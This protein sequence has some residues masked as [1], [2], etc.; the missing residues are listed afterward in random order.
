[1]METF[2]IY[3][4]KASG[5]L[6]LFYVIYQVF[7]K[8]DTF[9]NAN[10][11][12][13]LA[14]IAAAFLGPMVLITKYI[15]VTPVPYEMVEALPYAEATSVPATGIDWFN[16]AFYAYLIGLCFLFIRFIVQLTSLYNICKR[17][18]RIKEDG[19]VIIE[20]VSNIAPFSFLNTIVYN[21]KHYSESELR[22]IISHEKAHCSQRHTLDVLFAHFLTIILWINPFSWLYKKS[23]QQNLEF[24]ADAYAIN[25]ISSA[26]VYQYTLLKVSGNQFCTAITNNFHNSLIKKRIVM[27]QK[28]KSKKRSVFK[29]ALI[30][31]A[32]ALF[33]L[34]FNTTEV[35]VPADPDTE[36]FAFSLQNSKT[37]QIKVDK[38]T[39]DSDLKEIKREL[40]KK[41][42]DF[43]Y[44]IVRNE[45]DEI[46]TLNIHMAVLKKE[47]KQFSASSSYDNDGEP[48]DDIVI[49]YDPDSNTFSLG[50]EP[51]TSKILHRENGKSVWVFDD[52]QHGKT[53]EIEDED[54]KEVI[55]IDGEKVTRQEYEKMKKEGKLHD[56]HIKIER[57]D[58]R[59]NSDVMIIRDS[60]DAHD[61]D[62]MSAVSGSFLFIDNDGKEPLYILDG[63]EV[64]EKTVKKLS[65]DEVESIDV[66]KGKGAI[67]KYGDKAKDGVVEITTKK[68]N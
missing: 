60:D 54:G 21:P 44:D 40:A 23:I 50:G 3:L 67:K 56:G 25:G 34:S 16:I 20:T 35:Y 64:D 29:T 65:A 12:F 15:E 9:F 32:L 62:I 51:H 48:I 49:F 33:L 38:N 2:F 26:K 10:R 36:Q 63:K 61:I 53:I 43:S 7:L 52:E 59:R 30:I 39:S 68:K 28:S 4:L 37:I 6:A 22:D 24:L 14:G 27:L 11:H 57:S 19:F 18:N 8:R 58:S 45:S 41:G 17:G 31:P 66:S 47:G 13:L 46:I 42:I 55:R 1:M 5:I